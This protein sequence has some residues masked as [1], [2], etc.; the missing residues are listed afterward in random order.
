MSDMQESKHGILKNSSA[1]IDEFI[2]GLENAVT[3]GT[4][5]KS[6]SGFTSYLTSVLADMNATAFFEAYMYKNELEPSTA[7]K[8]RSLF[9]HLNSK[10]LT[11]LFASPSR[12]RF[13]I[14]FSQKE[15]INNAIPQNKDISILRLNADTEMVIGD[16]HPFV[17][18]RDIDI[19]INNRGTEDNPKYNIHAKYNVENK[20]FG[21]EVLKLE[22][23]FLQSTVNELD[24][25]KYFTIFPLMYQLKREYNELAANTDNQIYQISFE[26]NLIGFE[27]YYK[28]NNSNVWK[29]LT[30]YPDGVVIDEG[31]NYSI[32]DIIDNKVIK[33]TFSS[34]P[35]TFNPGQNSVLNVVTF[36]SKGE[37]GNFVLPDS[38]FIEEISL[39]KKQDSIDQYQNTF[40]DIIP[41]ISY[42][43]NEAIGGKNDVLD[44]ETLRSYVTFKKYN[45]S[46]R[47]LTRSE[48][49]KYVS[50]NLGADV[51]RTRFDIRGIDFNIYDT[52]KN[53][54]KHTL[55]SDTINI[56][57]SLDDNNQIE[58][59]N[60]LANVWTI[61]PSNFYSKKEDSSYYQI[62]D[63]IEYNTYLK[64]NFDQNK[65]NV[66]VFPFFL[67]LETTEVV[68][69]NV[70]DLSIDASYNPSTIFFNNDSSSKISVSNIYIKRNPLNTETFKDTNDKTHYLKNMYNFVFYIVLTDT[71]FDII[72]EEITNN[73]DKPNIKLSDLNSKTKFK[74]LPIITDGL[75]NEYVVNSNLITIPTDQFNEEDSN[76]LQYSIK[77]GFNLETS[78]CTDSKG[79]LEIVNNGLESIPYNT[80]NISSFF[81]N[82]FDLKLVALLEKTAGNTY[83]DEYSKYLTK[84]DKTKYYVSVI[85]EQKGI[86]I[87]KNINEYF[88]II[89]DL[90]K[91]LEKTNAK[92]K[93]Y[94]FN[95]YHIHKNDIYETDSSGALV[96]ETKEIPELDSNGDKI[97]DSS[98]KEKLISIEVAKVKHKRGDYVTEIVD[99]KEVK[100]IKYKKGEAIGQEDGFNIYNIRDYNC[101]VF[102][103]P[104][105]DRAFYNQY[106]YS[107]IIKYY[108]NSMEKI[109]LVKD[110]LPDN[111]YATIGFKRTNSYSEKFKFLDNSNSSNTYQN[112]NNTALSFKLGVKIT[113]SEIVDQKIIFDKIKEVI[114][115]YVNSHNS[116][117]FSVE[118]MISE[119]IRKKISNI[120]Y[121]ELYKINNYTMDQCQTISY[122]GKADEKNEVLTIK[123]KSNIEEISD[124]DKIGWEKNITFR[125][126]IDIKII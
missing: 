81:I 119:E 48:L 8:F 29:L 43:G 57:I 19:V 51:I 95:V 20:P 106:T 85:Y 23:H 109:N 110:R 30:G 37:D 46:S 55:S 92:T 103:L 64:D 44:I 40:S 47:I 35:N 115:E 125:P 66:F 124:F 60:S 72:K 10:E 65:N 77:C 28:E 73:K 62:S 67:R 120:N 50:D 27:V 78:N 58:K 96:M 63:N 33:I 53:T 31:F 123:L 17:L 116:D 61:P 89:S 5:S 112:L 49:V 88:N 52:I 54:N 105:I 39:I 118:K 108:Y 41:I 121:I 2:T 21:N 15:L 122:Q 24:G 26:D 76:A 104:V 34:R 98:G 117:I 32:D 13:T 80:N 83:S 22:D 71:V 97:L 69:I 126:D 38:E 91:N 7:K 18:A 56:L 6:P 74:I 94:P 87:S 111:C 68:D 93:T 86:K 90:T 3:G 114:V 42:K 113:N 4:I 70:L 12:M 1:V 11:D 99:G 101:S 84:T 102:R 79:Y 25:I 100:K 82:N 14:G 36:T 9:R 59:H 75:D 16:S 45:N 107:S